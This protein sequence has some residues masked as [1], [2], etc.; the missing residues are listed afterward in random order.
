MQIKMSSV[1]L[2]LG[3]SALFPQCQV[4][5]GLLSNFS[6]PTLG[7]SPLRTALLAEISLILRLEEEEAAAAAARARTSPPVRSASSPVALASRPGPS[8]APSGSSSTPSAPPGRASEEL[9]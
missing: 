1:C 3:V 9:T 6:I 8:C 5:F 4:G 2:S 7:R